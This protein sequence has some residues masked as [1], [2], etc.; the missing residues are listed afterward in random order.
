MGLVSI[1]HGSGIYLSRGDPINGVWSTRWMQ[2]VLQHAPSLLE[3]F[4]VREAIEAKAA[5]LAARQAS[6]AE[7][8]RL[9]RILTE[10]DA[11]LAR[12]RAHL[13][14]EFLRSY[15]RLDAAFHETVAEITHN[16]FLRSLLAA[17]GSALA[18]SREAT[19]AMPGRIE[20]SLREHW[21]VLEAVRR[22]DAEGARRAMEDHMRRVIQEVR[23]VKVLH[24]PNRQPGTERGR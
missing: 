21:R 3:M 10:A 17:L 4:E 11:L 22:R 15:V 13:D 14:E 16:G 7:M 5:S 8:R 19:L 24:R 1:R 6:A 9:E 2:W 12:G 18:E 20:R 23:S